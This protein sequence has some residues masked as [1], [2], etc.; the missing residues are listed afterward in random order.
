MKVFLFKKYL[1]IITLSLLI[2]CICGCGEPSNFDDF[3]DIDVPEAYIEYKEIKKT[4]NMEQTNKTVVKSSGIIK[5]EKK[6]NFQDN[7]NSFFSKP[8]KKGIH[9]NHLYFTQTTPLE[10][11][12]KFTRAL[13]MIDNGNGDLGVEKLNHLASISPQYTE[14]CSQIFFT[15]SEFYE[16]SGNIKKSNEYFD[17]FNSKLKKLRENKTINK[18]ATA[19]K[20][21]AAGL[22]KFYKKP[23]KGNLKNE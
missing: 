2:P 8:D 17:K 4:K 9:R 3:K 15:I 7:S 5:K 18:K 6:N 12:I 10:K 20:K 14:L 23:E 1:L 13:K 21:T 16:K 11:R 22:D 19:L